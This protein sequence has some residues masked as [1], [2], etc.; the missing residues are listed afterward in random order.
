[1]TDTHLKITSIHCQ[2]QIKLARN[3]R[4]HTSAEVAQSIKSVVSMIPDVKKR[5]IQVLMYSLIDKRGIHVG[6]FIQITAV[7][8]EKICP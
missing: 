4:V 3:L 7:V 6:Y 2:T 1:M 5:L 8:Y